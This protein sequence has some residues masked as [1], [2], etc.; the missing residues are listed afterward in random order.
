MFLAGFFLPFVI[1][2]LELFIS[3]EMLSCHYLRGE[4]DQECS[5]CSFLSCFLV[6]NCFLALFTAS[7][8][9]FSGR[10]RFGSSIQNVCP[11]I[12]SSTASFRWYS[13]SEVWT[14]KDRHLLVMLT[15]SLTV[16]DIH[17]MDPFFGK[18]Y[19]LYRC[20][21][22]YHFSLRLNQR[23]GSGLEQKYK[24]I[25]RMNSIHIGI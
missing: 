10:R 8:P 2:L 9:L 14:A 7:P 15:D 24:P 4:K 1:F 23:I 20:I 6:L 11:M 17:A 25:D 18:K 16:S 13:F 5:F 3:R 21:S 12:T 19:L 22:W